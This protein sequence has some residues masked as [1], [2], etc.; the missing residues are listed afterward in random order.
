[1]ISKISPFFNLSPLNH[2]QTVENAIVLHSFD[3]ASSRLTAVLV[4]E[5]LMSL[6]VRFS[7]PPEKRTVC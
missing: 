6:A 5:R 2:R 4:G 1:M 7:I 3:A